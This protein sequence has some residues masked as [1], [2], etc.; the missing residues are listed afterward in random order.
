MEQLSF[1]L[2]V[3]QKQDF[4][5]RERGKE[6]VIECVWIDMEV[7]T[8]TGILGDSQWPLKSRSILAGLVKKFILKKIK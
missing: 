6:S 4:T 7:Y 8:E 3:G 2:D 1:V 5:G